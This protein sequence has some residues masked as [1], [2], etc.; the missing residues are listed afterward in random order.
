MLKEIFIDLNKNKVKLKTDVT[1]DVYG[2]TLSVNRMAESSNPDE[3]IY[4][5]AY[6]PLSATG[7]GFSGKINLYGISL[8]G[9]NLQGSRC[10]GLFDK[11]L[12]QLGIIGLQIT[13]NTDKKKVLYIDEAGNPEL[14]SFDKFGDKIK[15][16]VDFASRIYKEYGNNLGLALID[17]SSTGF[18][19]N[20]LVCNTKVGD[21]PN[22][23]AGRGTTIFGKN[24]LV[25]IISKKPTSNLHKLNY[26]KKKVMELIRKITLAKKN[27]NLAG[28]DSK[29]NPLLGGTYG[30]AAK[31]RFDFGHGLTNLFRNANVPEEFYHSIL[32]D[33]IVRD[34]IKLA[35]KHKLKIHRHSCTP[36]CPNKCVQFVFIENKNREIKVFKTGEWET[37]QGVINLG[38]FDNVIEVSSYILEHSNEFAYDHIEALVALATLA[39]VSEIKEDTSVYYGDKDSIISALQQAEEGKTELGR[40]LRKGAAAIEKHYGIERHFTVG[41]HALPFHNGRSFIQTG[42]G[43]SWTF[44]RHGE[45]C[46]GPGRHNF[47]GQPYDPADHS[48]K[49]KVHILNTVHSMIMYGAFDDC[50]T[51]YFIGPNIDT[52]VDFEMIYKAMGIEKTVPQMIQDSAK[53]ILKIYEYNKSRGIRIQSLPKHF[54]KKGTYGNKQTVE[55][56]VVL[57]VPFEINEEY[58]LEVLKNVASGKQTVSEDILTKSRN[59]YQN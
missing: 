16:T 7:L 19:Y 32:P 42:V 35:D 17:P 31:G 43:L 56:S 21:V 45:C 55:D 47:I 10:G 4:I 14:I 44:G 48:L 41:K 28:S 36:G 27:I 8:I 37:V 20:A 49:P 58:G 18:L 38:V 1:T 34:Q 12:T 11:F 26:D 23:A 52:L 51:C 24:G 29:N 6:T 25:G 9:G 53:S 13:G 40:L 54:Y 22:H 59:R 39:L 30:S 50:G 33:A 5:S 46:A 3:T 57:N 2:K 15:G